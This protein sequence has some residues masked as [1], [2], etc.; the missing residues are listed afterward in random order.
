MMH[1]HPAHGCKH[2]QAVRLLTA[3]PAP[4]P[5]PA[6]VMGITADSVAVVARRARVEWQEEV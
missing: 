2:V 1:R 4:A 6:P 3:K 5:V